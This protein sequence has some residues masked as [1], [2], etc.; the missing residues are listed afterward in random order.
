M[1][2]AILC[3]NVHPWLRQEPLAIDEGSIEVSLHSGHRGPPHR[4][5]ATNP[6]VDGV[7]GWTSRRHRSGVVVDQANPRRSCVLPL[8][9]VHSRKRSWFA[10][11]PTEV[12][13]AT[14][15]MRS[16][17]MWRIFSTAPAGVRMPGIEGPAGNPG[18]WRPVP[19]P[20]DR[21]Q[22][23]RPSTTTGLVEVPDLVGMTSHDAR[24][25]ARLAELDVIIEEHPAQAGFRGRVLRQDPEPGASSRPGDVVTV[26]VGGRP[27]IS[28]PDLRAAD[29]QDALAMLRSAGLLPS[30]RV[31]RRSRDVPP[32]SVI[33]T[34]PRAGS[35]VPAGTRIA[36]VI[37][38][39]ERPERASARREAKR[40]RAPRMPDGGFLAMPGQ[41]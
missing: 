8:E 10:V 37:A 33:R 4:P 27:M 41:E 38:S 5:T 39:A 35:E 11:R 22:R 19:R 14:T 25:I 36:Y 9:D 16:Q 40:Q 23:P 1:R 2:T 21:E 29:E 12:L 7:T 31:L 28:I 30:R 24:R 34:R 20:G 15:T 17:P 6:L 32:G 26:A 13:S 18:P 3:R